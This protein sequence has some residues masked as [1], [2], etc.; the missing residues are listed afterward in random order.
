MNPFPLSEL[1]HSVSP[2]EEL[3]KN[4]GALPDSELNKPLES[5]TSRSL[6]KFQEGIIPN[7]EEG[8]R[9][10]AEVVEELEEKYPETDNY[11]I[12]SE[13][14]LRDSEGRIVKD[15]ETGE[16]RRIDFVVVKDAT[17]VESIEVTSETADK[18]LQTTKENRIREAGGNYI[19]INNGELATFPENIQTLIER[20][21]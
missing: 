1:G 13:A 21:K 2:L 20:R 17:V 8:L 4:Y 6:E 18:T 16:A 15:P 3:S 19:R 7:K 12:V 10:E 5:H 14:Y 11:E 9:R